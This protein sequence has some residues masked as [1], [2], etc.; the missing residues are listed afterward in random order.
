V[1]RLADYRGKALIMNFWASW[2]GA[3]V[4]EH[5]L[6]VELGERLASSDRIKMV[7]VDYKDTPEAAQRFLLRHGALAY[8]SGI[9][10]QGRMGIDYGVYGLPE[11]FFIDAQGR[12]VAK[13]IGPLTRAVL[14]RNLALLE[15]RR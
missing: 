7:G 11:T 10:P 9:D 1:V 12:I 6:L 4:S 8:P 5:P 14:E 13:Q 15:M 2:C 3:C